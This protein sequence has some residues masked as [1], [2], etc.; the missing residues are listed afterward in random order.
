M[1][2]VQLVEHLEMGGLERLVVDLAVAH[3]TAGHQP[4]IYCLHEPGM[5]AAEAR[6]ADI[7]VTAFHKRP[8]FSWRTLWDLTRQLR[9]D[10]P[11]V[12]HTHNPGVHHYGA[13]AACLA[14]VP[15]VANT[16]HGPAS[17]GGH[18]R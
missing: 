4:L 2:I 11:E 9:R 18:A 3:K 5:L 17:S 6:A 14:R 10:A 7:P 12:L 8:G 1:R 16:R 13:L 15:A